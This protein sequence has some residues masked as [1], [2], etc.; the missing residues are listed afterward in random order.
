M[1]DGL[2]I[3]IRLLEQYQIRATM[4]A[5]CRTALREQERVQRYVDRGH[6]L[7][8]HGLEH[9]PPCGMDDEHFR[10]A[11]L[12][13]KQQLETAFHTQVSG[14]RAPCF[15]L[16]EEKLDIVRQLGFRYDSSRMDFPAARHVKHLDMTSYREL[17][18]GIYRKGE[19][20]EFSLSCQRLFG[21]NYPISGG[22]Y[23]RLS[24][25][26]FV[27]PLLRSY[28]REQDYY[29]F[30]L[31]PFELSRQH[32]PE[33]AGLKLYDRYYLHHGLLSEWRTNLS[34]NELERRSHHDTRDGKAPSARRSLRGAVRARHP[35]VARAVCPLP[36][37]RAAGLVLLQSASA[38]AWRWCAGFLCGL[39][40]GLA[41]ADPAGICRAARTA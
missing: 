27:L 12:A 13:G 22:G 14:Y 19:F 4:F 1:L 15:G 28:L 5:V 6:R 37:A 41:G 17:R 33:L 23:V 18:P 38:G 24:N 3:Y 29:V 21:Q 7:A 31:H 30:Y 2:D 8:L 32:Q 40:G 34:E 36:A 35:R 25:W 10:R 11:T 20:Y 16:D 9:V 26:S 39:H